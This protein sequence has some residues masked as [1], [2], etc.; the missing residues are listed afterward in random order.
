MKIP[1][2][3]FKAKC[4]ALLDQVRERGE[5]IT[6]TKRGKVVARLVAAGDTEDRPWLRLRH[7]ARWAG[8]ALAPPIEETDIEALK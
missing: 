5:P 7:L 1:A 6:V 2:S 3:E 8:D 4:L